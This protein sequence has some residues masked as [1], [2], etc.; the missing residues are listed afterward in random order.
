MNDITRDLTRV[1]NINIF[2]SPCA[3][4]RVTQTTDARTARQ[5]YQKYMI[6]YCRLRLYT[7]IFWY[8]IYTSRQPITMHLILNWYIFAVFVSERKH[9]FFYLLHGPIHMVYA[10]HKY[11]DWKLYCQ[12]ICFWNAKYMYIFE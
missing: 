3:F 5:Y 8:I 6:V 2:F 1:I 9:V 4:F 10:W 7:R 12:Q 11:Q